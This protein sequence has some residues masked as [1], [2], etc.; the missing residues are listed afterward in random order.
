MTDKDMFVLQDC[1]QSQE[2]VPGS[3]IETW[4]ASSH[5]AFQAINLK[6]EELSDVEEVEDPLPMSFPAVKAEHAVSCLF[7]FPSDSW[8]SAASCFVY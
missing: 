4:P 2:D 7:S 5:D 8:A 6:V 1:A 3:C